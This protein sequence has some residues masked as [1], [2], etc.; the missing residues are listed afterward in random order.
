MRSA[1]ELLPYDAWV[2]VLAQLFLLRDVCIMK[3]VCK[4]F[5]CLDYNILQVVLS[6]RAS[7]LLKHLVSIDIGSTEF[8]CNLERCWFGVHL[9]PFRSDSNEI[10]HPAI[11]LLR[12]D[13]NHIVGRHTTS[14]LT[15]MN[16][17][18]FHLKIT[19]TTD[20]ECLKQGV[21]AQM[22]VWGQNGTYIAYES[23]Y[24]F[25]LTAGRTCGLKNGNRFLITQGSQEGYEVH[26]L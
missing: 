7:C 4:E 14:G 8:M 26:L 18:R 11:I 9:I 13:D 25:T 10:K 6:Q 12:G 24:P 23:E 21:A 20:V 16:I 3:Q 15:N 2:L 1:S 17:S 5:F 22:K 19:L